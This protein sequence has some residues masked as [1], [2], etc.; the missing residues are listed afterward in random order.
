MTEISEKIASLRDEHYNAVVVGLRRVHDDLAIM[1]VRPDRP[2]PPYEPGQW[3]ALGIGL[4]ERR[5]VGMPPEEITEDE[6]ATLVRRPFS[7][8]S[9][10]LHDDEPR[11]LRPEEEDSYEFYMALPHGT[12]KPPILAARLFALEVGSR[13]W[14]DAQ[15]R[16]QNTLAEVQPEDDVLFAATGTGES[17]HNRM[18]WQLLRHGHRGRI[19]SVVT[20]RQVADQGYRQVHERVLQLFPNYRHAAIATREPGQK[21]AHLQELLL[22]GQL[23]ELTGFKLDPRRSRVFL[24]GNPG[25]IGAPRLQ[26][27]RAVYPPVLGM[28]EVLEQQRG[29]RADPRRGNINIHFERY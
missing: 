27:S 7:I 3:I 23:E 2:I 21:G 29:F 26:D 16:G 25:M 9:R 19:A 10:I 20:T 28:V 18:I 24:C 5:V 14:V 8:G 6:L 4:W 22:N 1:R 15:P 13:L 11:L 17:P 12:P